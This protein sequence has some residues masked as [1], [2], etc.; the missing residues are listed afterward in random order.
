M[1]IPVHDITDRME[2]TARS[3]YD[4][5][6]QTLWD[7]VQCC[8]LGEVKIQNQHSLTLKDLKDQSQWEGLT[9]LLADKCN[10]TVVIDSTQHTSKLEEVLKEDNYWL[11]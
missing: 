2:Q 7:K 10:A 3:L 9:I 4:K 8:C 5:N 11:L 1:K 6:V